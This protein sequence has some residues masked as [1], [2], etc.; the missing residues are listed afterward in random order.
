MNNHY[1]KHRKSIAASVA[2]L[3]TGFCIV[4]IGMNVY[5]YFKLKSHFATGVISQVNKGKVDRIRPLFNQISEKLLIIHDLGKNGAIKIQD[6]VSLNRNFFPLLKNQHLISGVILA[7]DR[8][9]EYFLYRRKDVWVTRFSKITGQRA[10]MVFQ[11]WKKPDEPI[12]KWEKL[13]DYDPRKRPWFHRSSIERQVYWSPIYSFFATGKPGVTA[14][15]SWTKPAPGSG[16]VVF[17]LDIPLEKI[18]D[19]LRLENGEKQ[20]L[21][22]LL[23]PKD[24]FFI[25]STQMGFLTG[26]NRK[27]DHPLEHGDKG[28]IQV[29]FDRWRGAGKPVGRFVGFSFNDQKWLASLRPLSKDSG[30]FW[31][32]I[33]APEKILLS[34]LRKA[35]FQVDVT[36]I[37]VATVGGALLL[38]VFWRMGGLG[39]KLE[40]EPEEP[41]VRLMRYLDEGEGSRVEFKSTVRTNLQTGKR[42]KEIAL[43][44]L[45]AVVAFLNSSGGAL[46]I[47]VD[48]R[49]KIVGIGVDGFENPDK[50]QLHLKNLI[51]QHIGAEFSSFIHIDLVQ[52][53]GETV[54]LIEC[55][56]AGQ[57]VFLRI[58][59][60]EE[61]Y[62][63][64]GPSSIR[65]S[66]SQIVSY[67]LQNRKRAGWKPFS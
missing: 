62:V 31:V 56:P 54:I 41:L 47:G 27:L 11:T 28:L 10:R 65:L 50:C 33:A 45:K 18:Q 29:V 34:D 42:G 3:L 53:D 35:L 22:F 51:N 14:S 55:R 16:F 32:G 59:K 67:V 43:A 30:M 52:V 24:S 66:P 21:L 37:V 61:F 20:G 26:G 19:L 2:I 39:H 44:W 36:D 5:Q 9:Y 25:T 13:A 15:I 58:G 17:A 6:I 49:G 38:L 1:G 23:N 60:K 40:K 46:L 48:D 8:G 7:D 57:P 12:K 64:S 4:L 63:R